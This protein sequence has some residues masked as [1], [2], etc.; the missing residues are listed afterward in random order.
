MGELPRSGVPDGPAR[1]FFDELHHLHHRAGW[2]SLRDMAKEVGCSHTTVS[3]AFS[4]TTVPRWG[5]VELIVET[6]GGDTGRFHALWLAATAKAPQPAERRAVTPRQLPRDV[7]AFTGRAADLAALE[8]A[9]AD[10]IAVV[11]GTGGVGKTALTV[12]W[13]HQAADRFPDGQCYLDLRGYGPQEPMTPVEALES[14]LVAFGVDRTAM[15]PGL[16]ERAALYRTTL[17]GRRA[18]V[19]LDNACSVEQVRDLL[20][21]A[22]GCKVVV[23]SRDTLPALVARY[24]AVRVDLDVLGAGE[25]VALLRGLLGDRVDA[26]PG[27]AAEL[28]ERCARLP[29]ALRIAAELAAARPSASLSWLV[30]ELADEAMTLDLLAAGDD[31]RTAVRSVFSWSC[32][33]L[34]PAALTAFRLLGMFPGNTIAVTAAAALFDTDS[35][36]A[37]RTLDTLA[38]AHL[39]TEVRPNWF[40]MHDLL[41]TYAR[42]LAADLGDAPR[43]RVFD[44][45][46]HHATAAVADA[47]DPWLNDE[48]DNLMAV[49]AAAEHV[50]PAYTVRL[51]QCLGRYLD[52]RAH[53]ADGVTLHGLAAR[54]AR[55][56]DDR[57]AEAGAL[58]RLG[59]AL[60]R[61]ARYLEAVDCLHRAAA[62]GQEAGAKA[63]EADAEH[64][65]GVVA[66][67]Q[68]DYARALTRLGAALE[69]RRT[70]GDR[71]GEGAS[72]YGLGT[73][74]RQLG[75]YA[76]ALDHQRRA[77]LIYEERADRL[78]QSRVLN[79]LG[80]TL[81][82]LGRHEEAYTH[83]ER[84]LEINRVIGNRVG[85]AVALTNLGSAASHLGRHQEA[86]ALHESAMRLYPGIGY[87]VGEADGRY[88]LGAALRRAGRHAEAVDQLR[89]A[90]AMARD[91]REV[92]VE[93]GASTE[94]GD[95]LR[96]SDADAAESAYRAALAV[97]D[98]VGDRYIQA[99]VWA[100]LAHLATGRGDLASAADH[101]AAAAALYGELGLLAPA[102]GSG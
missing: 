77:L 10:D 29:L 53:Y 86:I 28:A 71:A 59:T 11:T 23:T 97:A 31:A 38:R 39:V 76:A 46:L 89:G 35:A 72:L 54:V 92:D 20:P 43:L 14:L 21:G 30:A 56:L 24:G 95:A 51:S 15:P 68:G 64:T 81:E 75:D 70:L 47:R 91:V 8:R 19:V 1:T 48:H 69:I 60:M 98:R 37:H 49:A 13:A 50:S 9:T 90:I 22:P 100:G 94:L 58:N 12:R 16:D 5:L 85:E 3:T 34:D 67:R 65:L 55:A 83:Y 57:P 62:L 45:Y 18:L 33:N 27:G 73:V 79:N 44:H 2:P 26:Q 84:A 32:R 25:S 42:E 7:T 63:A 102:A 78:G 66:W 41:R 99:R 82:R 80:T 36:V 88:G 93:M 4:G 87:R 52:V 61:G 17:A 40:G 6:L 96:E 74:H 101:Q